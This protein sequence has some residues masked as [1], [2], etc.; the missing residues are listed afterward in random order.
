LEALKLA[1]EVAPEQVLYVGDSLVADIQ[2]AQNAGMRPVFMSP[3]GEEPPAGIVAIRQLSE[4][5]PL[6]KL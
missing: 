4:L 2:G 6:L 5:L 3:N 1:G